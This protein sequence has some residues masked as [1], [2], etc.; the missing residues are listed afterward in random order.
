MTDGS[1]T[2]VDARRAVADV[3]PEE[4]IVSA[5]RI[6]GGT[7]TLYRVETR[8]DAYVVKFNTFVGLEITAAEVAV[9]RLLA[10]TDVP[11]PRVVDAAL[12]PADGPAYFV[13]TALPGEPPAEVS[14]ALARRMGQTLSGFA[15][16]SADVEGYGRL[17]HA[18]GATPP[19][20]A[21][22]DTWRE[23]VDWYVEMLLA[24]PSDNVADL[25][26]PVRTVVDRTLDA[27]PRRPD[28]AIVPDDYR[29]ANV[30]VAD[31]E[32]VGVLDLERAAWGDLRLALV[33]SAYLLGRE[34]S[35]AE[36]TRLQKALYA[37]F[38]AD[39]PDALERCYRAAAVAS[40]IRGF[41]IWWDDELDADERAGELRATVDSLTD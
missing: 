36:A 31:G 7:N 26:D 40:E 2:E 9:Y 32:V 20:T 33:K 10:D 15:S 30:H 27:V 25:V 34:R 6:E 4:R 19:M 29:P 18:P 23:Y 41:D 13:M 21:S 22:A 5:A 35:P 24:K 28:P 11:V 38:D 8:E 37:G 39:V 3:L 12:D 17:Q 1:V 16:V 14:P